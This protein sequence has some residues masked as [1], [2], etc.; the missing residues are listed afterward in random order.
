V[1]DMERMTWRWLGIWASG[2][3]VLIGAGA[4]AR[5]EGPRLNQIQVIGSHNSYHI[6]PSPPILKLV[7]SAGKGRAEGLDYTHKPLAD[8]FSRLGIRQVELD[9]FADPDGGLYSNPSLRKMLQGNGKD[10]GPDP[11]ADGL[12]KKPGLKVLHVQ[13]VDFLS[14]A[15]TFVDG[16]KQIHD[17][18]ERNPRHV[19]ILVM[20]ELKD[21]SIFGLKTQPHKFG[22]AEIESVDT[23]ILSVFRR[24]EVLTPD[25][26]RGSFSS[27]PEAIKQH[28]WPELE[29]VRGLVMFALDNEGKPRDL[30]VDG[31]PALEGRLLFTTMEDTSNP[32]AAWFKVNEPVKEFERI[33]K[34]VKDGFL[35]RTRADADT[36]QARG[37]DVA[38]R[39]KALA[40]GAQFVSTDY[41]EADPRLSE[42]CV[43]LPGG[44]VARS[45]PVNGTAPIAD[46]DLEK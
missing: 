15:R 25:R 35:V 18:S 34:L 32:A 5:A 14:T 17:W 19:P 37:N 41:A 24:E 3:G 13:D 21:D 39:D 40:S 28:G 7:A 22:K 31:H 29:K 1:I 43:R 2:W 9:V 33:Q 8:Q 11:D 44:V 4:S 38:Q 23:E 36:K 26:V 16:L 45:N 6:A 20:V 46:K 27:L 42:Y 10:A 30:Y 12:L